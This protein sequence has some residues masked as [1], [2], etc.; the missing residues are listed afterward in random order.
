VGHDGP[1]RQATARGRRILGADQPDSQAR[2]LDGD[3]LTR[4]RRI[5]GDHHADA[6]LTLPR[7]LVELSVV[8]LR[9][10][11]VLEVLAASSMAVVAA[12]FGVPAGGAPVA[13]PHDR[14]M[15]ASALAKLSS[16]SP[17]PLN[18]IQQEPRY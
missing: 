16:P 17:T 2:R 6:L 1:H 5:L 9:Y 10:R 7:V 14:H 8:E 18:G 15:P 13:G 3:T 12:R 11:A 4:R